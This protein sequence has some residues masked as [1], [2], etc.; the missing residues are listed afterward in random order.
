MSLDL[1]VATRSPE[2]TRA[3]ATALAQALRAGDVVSLVGPLGAGKTQFVKGLAVGLGVPAATA[4]TSPTFD[5]CHEYPGRLRLYHLDAYRLASPA[6]LAA[7][8]FGEL[9]DAGGVVAVEWADRVARLIPPEA[10]TIAFGI[11]P[12]DAR[13]LHIHPPSDRAAELRAALAGHAHGPTDRCPACV[14]ADRPPRA[15]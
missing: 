15:D 1:L 12:S 11:T 14:A 4:V 13:H 10:I 5:L 7:I 6:E 2:Q 9:L 3:A 8:G